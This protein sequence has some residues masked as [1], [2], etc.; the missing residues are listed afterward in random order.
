MQELAKEN[1][2]IKNEIEALQEQMEVVAKLK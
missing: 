1:E 2:Q